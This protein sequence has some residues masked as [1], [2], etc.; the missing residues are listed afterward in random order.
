MQV[1][2]DFAYIGT[3]DSQVCRSLPA[4]DSLEPKTTPTDNV[5]PLFLPQVIFLRLKDMCLAEHVLS[6]RHLGREE[7]SEETEVSLMLQDRRQR[8]PRSSI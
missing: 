5:K 7:C 2:A 4:P 8:L 6:A 3:S 1:G